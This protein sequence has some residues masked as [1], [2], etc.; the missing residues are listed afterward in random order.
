MQ[1]IGLRPWLEPAIGL[2]QE[3][4]GQS[5]ITA[6]ISAWSATDA[7]GGYPAT[8]IFFLTVLALCLYAFLRQIGIDRFMAGSGALLGILLPGLTRLSLDG[9]LSHVSILFVFPFFASLLRSQDLNPRSFILFFSLTLAYVV[10]AYS[11]IAPV[12]LCT[13]FLG[14]LFVWH[15]KFRTKRLMLMSSILLITIINPFYVRSLIQFLGQQYYIAANGTFLDKMVPNLL[16]LHGWAE[17][18]FRTITSSPVAAL[19]DYSAILLGLLGF[20]GAVLLSKRDRLIFGVVLLPAILVIVYLAIR[21]PPAHYP[22]AKITLSILPFAIGL[23]FVPLSRFAGNS[24]G[25]PL[26]VL[27]KLFS[28]FIVAAAADGSVRYY[29]EVLNNRGLL[30]SFREPRFLDVCRELE[31]IKN[32]R[33]FVDWNDPLLTPWLCYH[34]RHNDVFVDGRLINDP[35]FSRLAPFSK[36]SDLKNIDFVVTLGRIADSRDATFS[37]TR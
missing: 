6:E 3:R 24:Q 28:A 20:A 27:M 5:I 17:L 33:V 30:R 16:T 32:K 7:K 22:I 12:G 34:A 10:A 14:V 37:G 19:S 23:F 36:I 35:A 29:S 9:F 31:E 18:V 25:R 26:G 4:I 1:D 11:E 8:V 13:L 15:D 21:T 2:K